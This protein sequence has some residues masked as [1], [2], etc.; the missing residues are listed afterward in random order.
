MKI[1]GLPSSAWTISTSRVGEG[2]DLLLDQ[3]VAIG[4]LDEP[5]DRLL[6][7]G[8]VAEDGLEDAAGRLAGSE[9]GDLGPA[10]EGAGRLAD[11]L[12]QALGRDLDLDEDRALGSGGGGDLHR[13]RSIPEAG[14]GSAAVAPAGG[15]AAAVR[16]RRRW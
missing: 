9:A 1:S 16:P 15:H 7:D 13:R 8:A 3:R 4:R 5:V 10:G 6:E 14:P 2:Q 12:G 11:G